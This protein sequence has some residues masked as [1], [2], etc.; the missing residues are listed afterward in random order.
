MK[1]SNGKRLQEGMSELVNKTGLRSLQVGVP[2]RDLGYSG[3]EF[4]VNFNDDNT[5]KLMTAAQ[6]MN[7]DQFVDF[8]ME[9][10]NGYQA[11]KT[12]RAASQMYAALRK[13]FKYMST[14][15]KAFSTAYGEFGEGMAE[16]FCTFRAAIKLA[17]SWCS[18]GLS[19]RRNLTS[20]CTTVSGLLMDPDI[21]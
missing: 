11:G 12:S 7:Q 8:V 2:N 3:L 15:P 10:S 14:D 17:G 6:R 16:N 13:M 20:Q 18:H 19:Y 21:S 4:N 5:M 9:S 1:K